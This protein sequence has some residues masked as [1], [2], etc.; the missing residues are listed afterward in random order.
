[1]KGPTREQLLAVIAQAEAQGRLTAAEAA[2]LRVGITILD[3]SRTQ[4]G[5]LQAALHTARRERDAARAELTQYQAAEA[6]QARR[7]P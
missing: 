5:G 7:D 3:S 2:L 4:V 6:Q 1:M